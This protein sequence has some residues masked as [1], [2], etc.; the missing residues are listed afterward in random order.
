MEAGLLE[1][2]AHDRLGGRLPWIQGP[3]RETPAAVVRSLQDEQ[4]SLRVADECGHARHH[5]QCRADKGPQIAQVGRD[6]HGYFG[7]GDGA[8]CMPRP[9]GTWLGVWRLPS[10]RSRFCPTR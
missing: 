7:D 10:T 2:F 1:D 4:A 3:G 5:D 9:A 6:W 8:T